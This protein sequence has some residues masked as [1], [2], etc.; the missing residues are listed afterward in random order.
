MTN[1]LRH[2]NLVTSCYT[3]CF[4]EQI[5]RCPD[6]TRSRLFLIVDMVITCVHIVLS[7]HTYPAGTI[8]WNNVEILVWNVTT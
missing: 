5:T 7:L 1:S 2:D 8:R 4:V 3:V 6:L